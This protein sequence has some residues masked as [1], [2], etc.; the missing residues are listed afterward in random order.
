MIYLI[1]NMGRSDLRKFCVKR[2]TGMPWSTR[3]R[4]VQ[5][6]WKISFALTEMPDHFWPFWWPVVGGDTF[7]PL[8]PIFGPAKKVARSPSS[9]VHGGQY[10]TKYL[11]CNIRID[12]ASGVR[13]GESF[14]R[15]SWTIS[16][17]PRDRNTR[18]RK[19]RY[20]D[21]LARILRAINNCILVGSSYYNM[22][23]DLRL[24]KELLNG[25]DL[26]FRSKATWK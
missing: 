6:K 21:L 19:R 14:R 17:K 9:T 22:L 15:L 5:K 24:Y 11:V 13:G 1:L 26:L 12:C 4:L 3:S 20:Y 16:Y 23:V 25:T 10:D 8:P 7:S 18:N 2:L